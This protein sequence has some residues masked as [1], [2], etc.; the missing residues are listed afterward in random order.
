MR[1][2]TDRMIKKN[3]VSELKMNKKDSTR[4]CLKMEKQM[5]KIN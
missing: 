4:K 3:Q 1:S 2:Q 5:F